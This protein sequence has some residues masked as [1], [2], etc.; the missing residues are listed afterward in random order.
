M[1]LE[2]EDINYLVKVDV[3]IDDIEDEDEK[4]YFDDPEI[5]GA[6]EIMDTADEEQSEELE[7]V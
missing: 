5:G 1:V 6:D 7:N 2:T 3:K 4:D